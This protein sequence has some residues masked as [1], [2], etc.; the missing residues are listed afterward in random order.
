MLSS[1]RDVLLSWYRSFV[2]KKRKKVWRIDRLCLFFT[3]WK[4]RN[5]IALK[6]TENVD[7]TIKQYFI[8]NFLEWVRVCSQEI[9]PC[10]CLTLL[11]G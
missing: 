5:M 4:E 8:F 10:H 11:I 2:G 6:N 9:A 1:V 3:V 7:Q